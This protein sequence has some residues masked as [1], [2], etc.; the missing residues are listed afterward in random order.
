MTR[1]R[2]VL[3]VITGLIIVLVGL[4]FII[5]PKGGITVAAAILS[6]TFTFRGIKKLGNYFSL[7]RYTVGGRMTLYSGMLYLELGIFTNALRSNPLIYILLYLMAAHAFSGVVDILRG[8]EAKRLKT[9]SWKYTIM[10]GT[11]NV[12]IAGVLLATWIFGWHVSLAMYAY[13]A[14]LIY[15]GCIRIGNAFRKQ[16][17]VY[18]Q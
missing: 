12:L 17:I 4:G 9:P 11:T 10:Y 6:L 7:A 8:I 5:D 1:G 3:N 2:R 18:I 15:S 16:A 14:G 13:G